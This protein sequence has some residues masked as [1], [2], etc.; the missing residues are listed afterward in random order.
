MSAASRAL[1]IA[2]NRIA[3]SSAMIETT[4]NS[5]TM[6]KPFFIILVVM[7]FPLESDFT[8]EAQAIKDYAKDNYL[9]DKDYGL[10]SGSVK[11]DFHRASF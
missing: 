4:T 10:D 9:C 2:G 5:S 6:V 8:E 3:I 1:P 11:C 7:W